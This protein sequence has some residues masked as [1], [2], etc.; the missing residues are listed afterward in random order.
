LVLAEG[1][2]I[3][4]HDDH[5]IHDNWRV[6]W[7]RVAMLPDLPRPE[8]I[9]MRRIVAEADGLHT[10]PLEF[11]LPRVEPGSPIP[12]EIEVLYGGDLIES[13]TATADR[14]E[15]QLQLPKALARGEVH[16]Y[17]LRFRSAKRVRPH[18]ICISQNR[19]DLF[20]LHVRFEDRL[21]WRVVRRVEGGRQ[22]DLDDPWFG[23]E[24]QPVTPGEIHMVFN[25]LVPN[26]AYGAQWRPSNTEVLRTA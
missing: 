1:T 2:G 22:R 24:V 10:L 19:V 14:Y 20:D 6:E 13:H 8:A 9:E 7:L 15:F 25:H 18:F 11:S 23:E 17:G 21:A 16:D 3:S 26:R 4:S 12:L 5:V